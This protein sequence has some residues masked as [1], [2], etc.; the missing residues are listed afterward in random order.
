MDSGRLF[1]FFW[2]STYVCTSYVIRRL[3]GG[4]W[5][6]LPVIKPLDGHTK[7]KHRVEREKSIIHSPLVSLL[8]IFRRFFYSSLSRVLSHKCHCCRP[9]ASSN[10]KAERIMQCSG[11]WHNSWGD[12]GKKCETKSVPRLA[13][14]ADDATRSKR[15]LNS[16]LRAVRVTGNWLRGSEIYLEMIMI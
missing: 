3:N 14:R 7:H 16:S 5:E 11:A 10:N 12:R 2:C 1:Q 8:L 13:S 9:I 6:C 4:G 15:D